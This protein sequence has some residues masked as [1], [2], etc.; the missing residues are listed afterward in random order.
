VGACLLGYKG[1][2]REDLENSSYNGQY[3][4]VGEQRAEASYQDERRRERGTS[5]VTTPIDHWRNESLE[6]IIECIDI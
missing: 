6:F 4:P 5:I 1:Q 3:H 2:E